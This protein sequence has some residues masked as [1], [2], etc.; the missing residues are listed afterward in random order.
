MHLEAH[1]HN[2]MEAGPHLDLARLVLALHVET[3]LDVA[4]FEN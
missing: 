4:K 2:L 1:D 3:T